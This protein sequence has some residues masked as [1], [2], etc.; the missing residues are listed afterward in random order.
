MNSVKI[1][2]AASCLLSL[3]T[4]AA[5][6]QQNAPASAPTSAQIGTPD[7]SSHILTP[8]APDK[9]RIN[10]ASVYGERPGKP[11]LY[12]IPATGV[13]PMTFAAK[14]L[15][16]GLT[17]DAQSG[18]ITG[19]ANTAGEYVVRLTARNH[20]GSSSKSLKIVIGDKIALSPPLG[21]NSWNSW[22]NRVDQETRC[23]VRPE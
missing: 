11:F 19:A 16:D 6:A 18:Q 17:L 15:P 3:T 20:L 5:T 2:S 22:A 21:W 4:L 7:Y 14:G 13:R 23:C 12:T 9:P 1:W 10:G 8:P